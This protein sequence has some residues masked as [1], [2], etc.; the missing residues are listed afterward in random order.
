MRLIT[1]LREEIARRRNPVLRW[2]MTVV[3]ST[4]AAL[5][6][7]SA[8]QSQAQLFR[9]A[10][11]VPQAWT[12]FAGALRGKAEAIL[13]S[14]DPVARRLQSALEV[15]RKANGDQPPLRVTARVWIAADGRVERI[16][17]SPVSDRV[18]PDLK[19]LLS[20]VTAGTPPDGMLQ[21][22]HLKL[23]LE[24]RG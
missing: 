3:M 20:R 7:S 14:D 6:L 12:E 1:R 17:V 24:P 10:V 16:A 8:G 22:V 23:S 11:D 4:G 5:A 19:T 18:D 2:L 9:P 13:S 15:L 21:P